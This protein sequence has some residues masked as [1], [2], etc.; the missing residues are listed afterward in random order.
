MILRC[1]WVLLFVIRL[2]CGE[3]SF[4]VWSGFFGV[5]FF[6]PFF[7]CVCKDAIFCDDDYDD[8]DELAIRFRISMCFGHVG[9]LVDCVEDVR[10]WVAVNVL[11]LGCTDAFFI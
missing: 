7:N 1:F 4:E 2:C 3:V 11:V 8:A 6:V 9:L 5:G 10:N